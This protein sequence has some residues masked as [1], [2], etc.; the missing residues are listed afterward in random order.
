MSERSDEIPVRE[1]A[2]VSGKKKQNK[3]EAL[4]FMP[5]KGPPGKDR[6]KDANGG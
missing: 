5:C 6:G 4:A 3:S 2:L 1:H